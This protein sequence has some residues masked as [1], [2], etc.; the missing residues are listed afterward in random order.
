MAVGVGLSTDRNDHFSVRHNV[1]KRKFSSRFNQQKQWYAEQVGQF[2]P[3]HTHQVSL[4]AA[5]SVRAQRGPSCPFGGKAY[6][7]KRFISLFSTI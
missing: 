1:T 2:D 4:T 5:F 7:G 6:L 3:V